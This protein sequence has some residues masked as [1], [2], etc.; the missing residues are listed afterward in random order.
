MTHDEPAFPTTPVSHGYNPDTS[1]AG[2]GCGTGLTKL[3]L[4]ASQQ[5]AAMITI[6]ET[7]G[8]SPKLRDDDMTRDDDGGWF[9]DGKTW[10]LAGKEVPVT[11]RHSV[12][13]LPKQRI[14]REA[15]EYALELLNQCQL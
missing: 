6:S 5:L 8:W 2:T 4:I 14:V 1:G 11:K 10:R 7:T 15:V 9:F 3:E 13:A 12:Q